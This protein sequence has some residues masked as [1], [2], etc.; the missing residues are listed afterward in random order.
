MRKGITLRRS[1]SA[2]TPGSW[3]VCHRSIDVD[4][5]RV[6]R[7]ERGANDESHIQARQVHRGES[8]P[9]LARVEA[10]PRG[11]DHSVDHRRHVAARQ[12]VCRKIVD[13]EGELLLP[14]AE[15]LAD[16]QPD[17][18]FLKP[19]HR[20]IEQ[21]NR[22]PRADRSNPGHEHRNDHHQR[23][24]ADTRTDGEEHDAADE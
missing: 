6:P 20:E 15:P 1:G 23:D 17:I 21:R 4:Q 3:V 12:A 5:A 8:Q 18:R 10:R 7:I 9:V 24:Q 22:R 14:N 16:D 2:S 11:Q 13:R 19:H